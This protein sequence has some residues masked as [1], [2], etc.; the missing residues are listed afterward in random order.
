MIDLIQE[1]LKSYKAANA[2][3]KEN[4]TKEILQ[5]VAR[6][7]A[8]DAVWIYPMDERLKQVRVPTLVLNPE[9][10]AFEPTKA[11]S[12]LVKDATYIDLPMITD[13]FFPFSPNSP[14]WTTPLRSRLNS[15]Q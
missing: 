1:R 12:R 13:I 11:A 6:C 2:V 14:P 15:T 4:A 9:D 5:E 3:E 7:Y 8:Y 10:S